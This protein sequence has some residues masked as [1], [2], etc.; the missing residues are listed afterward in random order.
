MPMPSEKG[1]AAI[2][3]DG[4]RTGRDDGEE[5]EDEDRDGRSQCPLPC[6]PV[7]GP[8]LESGRFHAWP[9]AFHE[10]RI[11]SIPRPTIHP[12]VKYV[13]PVFSAS[14][15]YVTSPGARTEVARRGRYVAAA[16]LHSLF[17]TRNTSSPVRLYAA[18]RVPTE[19]CSES[20]QST[21]FMHHYETTHMVGLVPQRS[22]TRSCSRRETC[23]AVT[24][25]SAALSLKLFFVPRRALLTIKHRHLRERANVRRTIHILITNL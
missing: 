8:W 9:A 24:T 17:S 12:S 7:F 25:P 20:V 18:M 21:F 2:A 22:D 1:A 14:P 6:L 19:L 13:L 5:D 23:R 11:Q 4:E 10:F 16:L 15:T 3:S